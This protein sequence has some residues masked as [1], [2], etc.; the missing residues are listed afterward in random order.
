M[1]IE[2]GQI[3]LPDECPVCGPDCAWAKTLRRV[4]EPDV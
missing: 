3:T 1:K 4:G 2:N